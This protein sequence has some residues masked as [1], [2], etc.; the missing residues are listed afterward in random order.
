M[1]PLSQEIALVTG[2]SRGLGKAIALALAS[3]GAR[4]AVNY[5]ASEAGAMRV[6]EAIRAAGGDALAV[7]A[8][9]TRED[10]LHVMVA[11]VARAWGPISVLVNNATGPQPMKA[12][13]DYTWQDYLDQLN[14]FVKA[15]LQLAQLVLPAM[16]A[17]R[18]GRIINIG[19][20]VMDLGNAHYSA[21][22]TAKAA[23]LG[24]TR[25][26][27]NE[28]GRYGI[29]VNLIAPGWIPVERHEQ[30]PEAEFA[31]YAGQLP[32]RRMGA[33]EDIAAAAVFFAGPGGKYITGQAL[34]VNGGNTF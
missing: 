12:I 26:W 34:S 5:F 14:F 27:A 2:A 16:K 15:P 21:Y 31:A 18:H 9:I 11:T 7:R 10:E 30:A 24:M 13:E 22:V 29:T 17:A 4:V 33:P 25:S 3:E 1:K 19:S 20:E 32:L 6:V 28:V 23:M 8:D